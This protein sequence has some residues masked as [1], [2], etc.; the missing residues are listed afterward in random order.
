MGGGVDFSPDQI[1]H[2]VFHKH[3]KQER[4]GWGTLVILKEIGFS[5]SAL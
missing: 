3:K 2:P 1:P 4:Q 5:R